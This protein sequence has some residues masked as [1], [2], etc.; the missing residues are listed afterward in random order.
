MDFGQPA[1]AGR[2]R[3][4]DER[5]VLWL[6]AGDA[7]EPV[8]P[9]QRTRDPLC[10]SDVVGLHKF[11]IGLVPASVTPPRTWK[12][13]AWF[14]VLSSAAVLVGLA[15]AAAELVGVHPP[16]QRIGM[17]AQL[18]ASP[19]LSGFAAATTTPPTTA[20]R[21]DV[22]R[23]DRA[24]AAWSPGEARQP[25]A[26]V[27]VVPDTAPGEPVPDGVPGVG[28]RPGAAPQPTVTTVAGD[29]PAVVDGAAL[30]LRTQRFFEQAAA[31]VDA[32]I[33]LVSAAFRPDAEAQLEHR[34]GDVA[35]VRVSE[36][37]VDAT[38]G[39]TVSTLHVTRKD[40]T[41]TTEK[42]QLVFATSGEPLI[43]AER[44]VDSA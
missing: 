41:T 32:A 43:E 13:A 10:D 5:A 36:I 33:A 1:R 18:T 15:Y 28:Q 42:R 16:E 27:P 19:L 39:V 8:L 24:D 40:G 9:L 22:P 7:P 21:L 17:P 2:H 35:A 4:A 29:A 31:N 3:L 26:V 6:P 34:I 12:R 20:A 11:N 14:A 38:R 30:V 44:L 23:V 37:T 25:A